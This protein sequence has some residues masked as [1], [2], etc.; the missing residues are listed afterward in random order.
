LEE[1]FDP[2]SI[3]KEIG[4]LWEAPEPEVDLW[5]DDFDVSSWKKR[6]WEVIQEGGV[7]KVVK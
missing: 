4:G 6:S 5:D 3:P 1:H 7:Y 2:E